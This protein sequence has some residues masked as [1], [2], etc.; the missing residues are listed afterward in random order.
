MSENFDVVS[1]I[2]FHGIIGKLSLGFEK[3]AGLQHRGQI[4][5]FLGEESRFELKYHNFIFL[6]FG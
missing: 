2:R 3:L 4:N 1:P 5:S 6:R